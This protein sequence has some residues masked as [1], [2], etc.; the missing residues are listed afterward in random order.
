VTRAYRVSKVLCG[1]RQMLVERGTVVL[2]ART[3]SVPA[4]RL[5][6]LRRG[7]TVRLSWTLGWPDVLDSLGGIPVL[8]RGGQIVQPKQCV[9]YFCHRNP[10]T[11]IGFTARGVLLLVTV[12]GR[13]DGWS[14]GMS[15]VE[16][17]AL[18]KRLGAVRA[19]N[20]D[21]G[22]SSTMV[23]GGRVVNRPSDGSERAVSSSILILPGT[24]RG[25][26]LAR[27]PAPVG[28]AGSFDA[29]LA[30]PGSTGGLLDAL[31]RGEFGPVSPSV[32]AALRA[33]RSGSA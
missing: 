26:P 32:R 18:F 13:R 29:A 3:G 15:L 28:R 16:F 8:V 11:G 9:T 22:G 31:G 30:D 17:A 25:D 6:G 2:S 21:G 14:E 5:H 7:R 33:L 12:D 27:S 19:L 20:L 23:V 1:A 10:R 24:D 4:K